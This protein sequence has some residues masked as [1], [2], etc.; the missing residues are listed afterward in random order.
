MHNA[1]AKVI[2]D[3]VGYADE[4]MFNDGIIAQSVDR[5]HN[6]GTFYA[7]AAETLPTKVGLMRGDRLL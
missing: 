3:D 7:S 4:P 6:A 2:V 5:V 1:G